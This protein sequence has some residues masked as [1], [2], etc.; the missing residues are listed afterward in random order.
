MGSREPANQYSHRARQQQAL[1]MRSI[2]AI[3]LS[4]LV[5]C[6]MVLCKLPHYTVFKSFPTALRECAEYFQMPNCT[7]RNY[8]EQDYPDEPI[9]KKL[10]HCTMVNL[11]SWDDGTGIR[12]FVFRNFFRPIPEDSCYENRTRECVQ[13]SLQYLNDDCFNS[14]AYETF[15][16]YYRHFGDL[17]TSDQYIPNEKLQLQQLVQTSL[18]IESL[19]RSVLARYCK[20]DILD[21][22]H[23]PDLMLAIFIRGGYYSLDGGIQLENIYTQLGDP[24][25]L[26]PQTRQ[27]CEAVGSSFCGSSHAE[28]LH[29][30]G[31]RCLFEI[32][33]TVQLVQEAAKLLIGDDPSCGC[34]IEPLP[35]PSSCDCSGGPRNQI[36]PVYNRV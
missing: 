16:C 33:P 8:I 24:E 30:I 25:L 5:A 28:K 1:S 11:A 23:F 7:L 10:L 12:E 29:Q 4:G 9:V 26:T 14:R 2:L 3:L 20:G 27:C 22:P 34:G 32:T 21:E 36:A 15:K 35:P 17:V 18:I 6:S 13:H 31:R 19:P